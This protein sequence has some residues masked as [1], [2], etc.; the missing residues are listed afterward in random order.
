MKLFGLTGGIGMGKSMSAQLLIQRGVRII[1]TDTLARQLV[2][3]GEPALAEIAQTFGK[4][5]IGPEG[6]LRRD[7]LARRIFAQDEDRRKLEEILHPRIRACWLSWVE[8][9][10]AEGHNIGVVV[11]PLLFETSAA[12]YFDATI[13]VACSVGTQ[14]RR[15]ESRGWAPGEIRQRLRAQWPIEKK[16]LLADYVV[17]TEA[18]MDVHADQLER[19]IAGP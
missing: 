17:W 9:L 3:P 1:D 2:E 15:L 4:E 12:S 14:A 8:I 18:G 16:M 5:I 19:I 11:I 10:R 13:C 6:R 7:E